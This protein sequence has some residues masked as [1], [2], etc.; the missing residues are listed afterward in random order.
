VKFDI[1]LNHLSVASPQF[2]DLLQHGEDS[3]YIDFF[4][5]WNKFWEGNGEMNDEGVMIPNTYLGQMDVNAKS[6]LVWEFYEDVLAKVKGYGCSILR[7]D[8]FAYLHKEVGE[9]NFFNKPGTWDYLA[10]INDIATRNELELLPE[11]HSE[12]GSYLHDEVAKEGYVIYDFFLP[13]LIIHAIEFGDN[14][15]LISWA[16]EII[17]KDYKTVNMLGCHGR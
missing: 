5:D 3:E 8:A 13:G 6:P 11:I 9:V 4:I 12:Y 15:P 7:L 16:K 2:K 1:V 17:V 14:G 10:K